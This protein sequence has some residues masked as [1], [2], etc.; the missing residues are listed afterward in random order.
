MFIVQRYVLFDLDL[1][2]SLEQC[3][4]VANTSNAHLFE[5]LVLHLGKRL[6]IDRFIYTSAC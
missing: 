5:V 6:P 4:S 2:Y 1:V 3:E